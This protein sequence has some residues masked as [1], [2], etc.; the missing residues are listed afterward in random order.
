MN[1]Q[2]KIISFKDINELF[3][4]LLISG[5]IIEFKKTAYVIHSLVGGIIVYFLLPSVISIQA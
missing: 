4:S 2:N 5:K 3:L 1:D